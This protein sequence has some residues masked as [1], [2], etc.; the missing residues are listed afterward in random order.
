MA[1]PLRLL[2]VE[3]SPED[4]ELLV[5][6]VKRAKVPLFSVRVETEEQIR[7]AMTEGDWDTVICDFNLPRMT[8]LD[9]I[10]LVRDISPD[11]PC[12][13]VSGSVGEERA[14][15]TML[16]GA[17][18]FITKENLS[19]LVPAIQREVRDREIRRERK[20]IEEALRT[21]EDNLRQAQRL[22]SI[23]QLAGGIAHDFNNI[24]A[25]VLLQAEVLAR[26][27]EKPN[28]NEA[29][30]QLMKQG[31]DQIRKSSERATHLTR[32]L[33]TFGR[34]QVLQYKVFNPNEL[35]GDMKSM[36]NRLIETNIDLKWDLDP[37]LGNIRI[38]P[39]HLEQIVINLVVNARDA[40]DRGGVLKVSTTNVD[41]SAETAKMIGTPAGPYVLLTISDTGSGMTDEVKK[42]IFE[43]FY[44]TKPV[45]KGTGLGLSTVYG[46]VKQNKGLI[47]VESAAGQGTSFKIYF[48]CTN[49]NPVIQR[50]A[51]QEPVH[52]T[53]SETILIVEDE[54]GFRE[55]IGEALREHGYKVLMAANGQDAI[56]TI[57]NRACNIDL[58]LTD[59]IMPLMGGIELAEKTAELDSTIKFIFQSGYT[60]DTLVA[61][62]ADPAEL[63][64]LSKPY[65]LK[66]LLGEIRKSL[67]SVKRATG[68]SR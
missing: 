20:L 55:L 13:V 8:A 43:P 63:T 6:H 2:L 23:G 16:A 5:A 52:V 46:I 35:I 53:G 64:F 26:N 39:G 12:I 62:G 66:D 7:S 56:E 33:L 28:S 34:K 15:E 22:E 25:T 1:A 57:K 54:E 21:S 4:S 17:S 60:E 40:M 41:V 29:I 3:D 31:I 11:M 24:M 18:D 50:S 36:L 38:D 58:V 37:R 32:Q 48:P 10:N 59:L 44:T 19:R 51:A 49:E 9:T 45:G 14:V 42:H 68:S 27:L 67:A 61:G 65:P 47:F 30:S